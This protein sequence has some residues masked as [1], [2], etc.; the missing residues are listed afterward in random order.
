LR[1]LCLSH[2][3]GEYGLSLGPLEF[4]KLQ[5]SLLNRIAS[6]QAMN[7]DRIFL[8][9]SVGSIGG[10]V[11]D[12]RVPPRVEDVHVI[13]GSQRQACAPCSEGQEHDRRSVDSLESFHHRSSVA[14]RSVDPKK[15]YF[16]LREEWLH[17]V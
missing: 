7:E 16:I 8:P 11:F 15:R 5:D 6:Y 1:A 10:L 14:S 3:S 2:F 9:D 12:S 13:S 17:A 4:L